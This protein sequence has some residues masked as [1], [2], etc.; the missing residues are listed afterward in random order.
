MS[1]PVLDNLFSDICPIDTRIKQRGRAL[2]NDSKLTSERWLYITVIFAILLSLRCRVLNSNSMGFIDQSSH[3][4]FYGV[5]LYLS[6][7]LQTSYMRTASVSLDSVSCTEN[8]ASLYGGG[9]LMFAA[10]H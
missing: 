3:T 8:K 4:I 2:L 1:Q 9:A 7:T 6:L 5:S 10:D